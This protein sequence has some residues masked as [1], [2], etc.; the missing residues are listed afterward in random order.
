MPLADPRGQVQPV[1]ADRRELG[2]KAVVRRYTSAEVEL[3]LLCW[4]TQ[5]SARVANSHV[6]QR[7]YAILLRSC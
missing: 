4:F 2:D 5:I 1:V 3:F 6:W 7:T